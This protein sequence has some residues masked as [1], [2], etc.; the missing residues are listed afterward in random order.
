MRD[1]DLEERTIGRILA[2]KAD[3][4]GDKTF[5]IW[6]GRRISYAELDAMTNRYANGFAAH[7]IGHGSHRRVFGLLRD[8]AE[9]LGQHHARFDEVGELA[10]KDIAVFQA[11]SV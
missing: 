7:G 4:I 5:L 3:R 8:G 2:D 10:K 6:Q 1:Y 11:D 9:R